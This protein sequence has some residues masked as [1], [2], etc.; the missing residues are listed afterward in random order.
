MAHY[1]LNTPVSEQDMRQLRV[2]D[3][4]TLNGVVFGIRDAT[5]RRIFD[6]G[7]A[8]PVDLRGAICLHT[9][10]NVKKEGT[11]YLPVCIGTTTSMRM[12]RFTPGLIEQ[13][14]VKGIIGKGGLGEGSAKAMRQ[15]GA[16]YL[17]I[18]GGAAA[19]QTIQIE[20]IEAVYWEDLMPECVWQLRTG[21]L[22]PLTVAIDSHGGNLYA[23]VREEAATRMRDVYR[24]LGLT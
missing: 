13:Y 19:L 10:P 9:A 5:Q 6:E 14:G 21:E 12:E 3:S 8:P 15:F 16:C 4:V 1:T 20:A 11:R 18:V 23:Q 24:D 22:G 7:I 17:A 2:G